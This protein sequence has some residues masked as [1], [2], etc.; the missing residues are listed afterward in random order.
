M[1]DVHVVFHLH[2]YQPPRDDPWT[3]AVPVEPSAA[4]AHDWN[5]RVTDECY[6]PL[7]A[8]RLLDGRGA[9]V[10][11]VNLYRDISVDMGATLHRWVAV[12][13]PDVDAAI[14]EGDAAAAALH[15]GHGSAVGQPYVHAILPL[16]TARDRA[17]LVRWGIADFRR[18]FGHDPEGM[19]LPEAAVDVDTLECLAA[20]GLGFTILGQ[21]QAARVHDADGEWVPATGV[22]APPR[23]YTARLP[24]GR[25]ITIV[26]YD[27]ALSHAVA[28]DRSL[29]DDGARLAEAVA[30]RAAT[31]AAPALLVLATDG[32]TFGHHHRFGEM[33]LARALHDLAATAGITVG[34]LGAFVAANGADRWAL[35]EVEIASPSAWSCAHG[36]ERWRT[37]CGDVTG[38]E[39]HWNQ[40]W[41]APLRAMVDLLVARAATA[42]ADAMAELTDDPWAVRDAYGT[43][44]DDDLPTRQAFARSV[45]RHAP[46]DAAVA[47]MLGLLE[48]QRHTLFAQSSCAWFFADCAGIETAIT[49]QHAA[50]VVEL[51]RRL[52]GVDL[53]TE[54]GAAL[55]PMTSNDPAAGDGPTLWRAAVAHAVTPEHVAAGWAA[56]DAVGAPITRFGGLAVEPGGDAVRVVD[57]AVGTDTLVPVTVAL[58]GYALTVR[59]GDRSFGLS[60]LPRDARL[61]VLAQ[62]WRTRRATE[63][64]PDV[65]RVRE[66]VE[67][68]RASGESPDPDVA[69]AVL[70]RVAPAVVH[71]AA[72]D[73]EGGLADLAFLTTEFPG[74]LPARVR[75]TAQNAVL[76]ARDTVLPRMRARDDAAA[77]EWRAALGRVGTALGVVT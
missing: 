39:P 30:A 62:W 17:T 3:G 55:A 38:G 65:A 70:L 57:E 32:E 29:L 50:R 13:A 20:E 68:T 16:A 60:D 73:P 37:D 53:D 12:H 24:S 5:Q 47:R 33:A 15:D 52:T 23:L 58:D 49:L 26:F 48:M 9:I 10:D 22:L 77:H 27:G 40:R 35:P 42:Y 21:H 45:A 6:R 64:P 41:R 19:W 2:C 63:A 28:F 4:P 8:A 66:L 59:A 25:A 76:A 1:S 61:A 7:R 72:A 67:V 14:R 71:R 46:D 54:I 56:T 18:R 69:E 74:P 44:V 11:A 75:W 43:V 36:V 34:G 51:V 31:A